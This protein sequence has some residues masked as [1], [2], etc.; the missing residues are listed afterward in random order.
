MQSK[1]CG[2]FIDREE[3]HSRGRLIVNIFNEII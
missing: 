2:E 1:D 3:N